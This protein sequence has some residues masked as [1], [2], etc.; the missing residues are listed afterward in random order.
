MVDQGTQSQTE[1]VT[2][3]R[4][5]HEMGGGPL[6]TLFFFFVFFS[7]LT[8]LSLIALHLLLHNSTVMDDWYKVVLSDESKVMEECTLEEG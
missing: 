3:K 2:S 1:Q 6:S 7:S 5:K 4:S 8:Y